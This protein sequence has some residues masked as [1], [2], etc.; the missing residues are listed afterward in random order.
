MSGMVKRLFAEW[1]PQGPERLECRR[2]TAGSENAKA[3]AKT[4]IQKRYVRKKLRSITIATM[5]RD[6]FTTLTF[7]HAA[8]KIFE[9]SLKTSS[10]SHSSGGSVVH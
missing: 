1:G 7:S 3:M 4:C 2:P 8:K 9:L 6:V 5:T 10:F